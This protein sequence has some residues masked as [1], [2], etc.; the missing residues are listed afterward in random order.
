MDNLQPFLIAFPCFVYIFLHVCIDLKNNVVASNNVL[1][2]LVQ[3]SLPKTG[4]EKIYSGNITLILNI[5]CSDY[6][7]TQPTP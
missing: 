3:T 2:Q 5:T 6:Y 4:G 1:V 7:Q